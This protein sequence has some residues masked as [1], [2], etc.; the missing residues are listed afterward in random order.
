M[1]KGSTKA[2]G[3]SNDGLSRKSKLGLIVSL[4]SLFS[5]LRWAVK[6]KPHW[7]CLISTTALPW[8]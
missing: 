8:F 1:A 2:Y 3:M 6:V 7:G 5:E 4:I